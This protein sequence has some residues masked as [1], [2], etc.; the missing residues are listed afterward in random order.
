MS[1]YQSA[2]VGFQDAGVLALLA[3]G[4]GSGIGVGGRNYGDL[5]A[6]NSVLAA[7]AHAN[8][9]AVSKSVDH[10]ADLIRAQGLNFQEIT[11]ADQI[12]RV[13][14]AVTVGDSLLQSS[15]AENRTE[16]IRISGDDRVEAVRI[17]GDN[18]LELATLINGLAK[19]AAECCCKA[20]LLTITEAT[21]TRELIQANALKEAEREL[22]R[23]ERKGSTS[24]IAT[25]MAQQTIMIN[26]TIRDECGR[27][28]YGVNGAIPTAQAA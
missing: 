26:N 2:G 11:R 10:N 4:G 21:K 28:Y 7:E 16:A 27:R 6:G 13:A 25:L 15:V 22:D 5:Y 8:G 18:R 3:G 12:N 14:T 20:Q 23:C 19:D 17:A 9:T 24:D 1:E